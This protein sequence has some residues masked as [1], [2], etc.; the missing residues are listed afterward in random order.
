MET[1]SFGAIEADVPHVTTRKTVVRDE[2]TGRFSE[3]LVR[4]WNFDPVD[5]GG[6]V[7]PVK[8]IIEA[9]YC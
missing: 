7:K 1:E 9:K 8:M 6:G 5:F 2:L 4:E 3:L